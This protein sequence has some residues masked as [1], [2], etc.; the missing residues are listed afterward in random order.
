MT[1]YDVRCCSAAETQREFSGDENQYSLAVFFSS[2][3]HIKCN[4][5]S[6]FFFIIVTLDL[7]DVM[8]GQS[9]ISDKKF[10]NCH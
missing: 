10:S 1:A 4:D 6:T 3:F 8:T 5:G 9:Q 7:F 2:N